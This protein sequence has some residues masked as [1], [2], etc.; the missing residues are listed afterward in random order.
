MRALGR[1]TL[2]AGVFAA[3]IS[4]GACSPAALT[5]AGP[6]GQGGDPAGPDAI[7]GGDPDASAAPPDGAAPPDAGPR[8]AFTSA[9]R[10]IVEPSDSGAAMRAAINGATRSVHVAMYLVTAQSFIDALVG[11]KN[12][13]K[14]VKVVLN[15]TFPSGLNENQA[16]YDK[17]RAA[18]VS[19]VWA[20]ASFQFMHAKTILV[21]AAEAWIMTMNATFTSPTDNREFLAVDT[22]AQDVAQ[23]EALF[24][25]DFTGQSAAPPGKLLVS[26]GPDTRELLKAL[27]GSA[28]R[29]VDVE[30]ETISD[31]QIVD[32]LI[33]AKAAK[34]SVRVVIDDN[35]APTQQQQ[36][37]VSDLKAKGIPVVKVTTPEI[38]AKAIVVDG[39]RAYVGSQNL[40]TN[41]LTRNREVGVLF[42]KASEVGKVAGAIAQ[43]FA[44][45]SPM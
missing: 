18:G 40:T 27:I 23:A 1:T 29:S 26:P 3:S 15:Q 12:A 13:G 22:D 43:D 35:P 42:D 39:A 38:H 24:A 5:T 32:A 2:L 4:A 25:A 34:R 16:A 37:A 28:T 14:D 19:V 17:L 8:L 9:V 33:A 45:G 36:I 41:S 10:I 44:A 20:P 7:D 30:A 31:G 6:A 21:D 11:R